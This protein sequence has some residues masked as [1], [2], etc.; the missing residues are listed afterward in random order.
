MFTV[1]PL[2]LLLAAV[3]VGWILVVRRPTSIAAADGSS[4]ELLRHA[5]RSARWSS[6]GVAGGI[7]SAIAI[8]RWDSLGRSVVL[9]APLSGW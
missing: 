7:A 9:A 2:V 1:L 8:S 4:V 6:A 5:S 3:G